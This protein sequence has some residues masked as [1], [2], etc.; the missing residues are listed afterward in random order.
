VLVRHIQECVAY[1]LAKGALDRRSAGRV[2]ARG[3]VASRAQ[4]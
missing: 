1:T 3:R 2:P 4:A